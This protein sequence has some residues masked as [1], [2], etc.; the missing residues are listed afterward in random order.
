MP[1]V[2]S[3]A[4]AA[5]EDLAVAA[6]TATRPI[7]LAEGLEAVMPHFEE[8]V[9]VDVALPEGLAV[10]VG[11]GAD[12]AVD[13]HRGDVD[14]GVA[15]IGVLAHLA[16]VAAQVAL[17]AEGDVHRRVFLLAFL[18]DKLH[19]LNELRVGEVQLWMVVG[20]ADGDDGEDAPLRHAKAGQQVV[21]LLQMRQVALVDAGNDVK[22]EP[23]FGSG[24]GDGL[25]RADE[26]ALAATHPV[27]VELETVEADGQR[28]Q[29]RGHKA[30]VHSLVV[31]PSVADDAPSH[32]ASAQGTP[33]FGQV[34]P[35]QGLAAGQDDGEARHNGALRNRVESADEVGQRHIGL[36][37]RGGAVAAAVAAM[38]VA[39]RGALPEEVV[40]LVGFG[41]DAAEEQA[42]LSLKDFPDHSAFLR[43][44]WTV[45]F[46]TGSKTRVSPL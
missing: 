2:H 29:T 43:K 41:L 21:N 17:A 26:T 16:L 31:E 6:L 1:V 28:T 25:A 12:G 18:F 3:A 9:L 36:A 39:A 23:A 33:Y 4:Q 32:S 13:E 45:S 19:Q 42:E 46:S 5:I 20:A 34:G 40:E 14:A 38:Q 11:A 27:V 8:V 24:N 22:V 10:D 44:T 15:E 37:R 7:A 30:L 35:Q